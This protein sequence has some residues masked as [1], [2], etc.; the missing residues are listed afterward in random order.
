M[1]CSFSSGFRIRNYR[2]SS[3]RGNTYSPHT[4]FFIA[5]VRGA[6]HLE[7]YIWTSGHPSHPS[8]ERLQDLAIHEH[9][10]E[11]LAQRG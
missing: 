4:G 5:P 8:D 1:F 10:D 7:F 9:F 3:D 2:W 6:Y 11:A